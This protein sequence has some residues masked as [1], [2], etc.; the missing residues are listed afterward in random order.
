VLPVH[1]LLAAVMMLL[2]A[3]TKAVSQQHC[4]TAASSASRPL[5][6]RTRQPLVRSQTLVQPQPRPQ[7]RAGTLDW[8]S[9]LPLRL[10]FE[11]PRLHTHHQL[12]L[13]LLPL[14]CPPPRRPTQQLAASAAAARSL[15]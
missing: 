2:M 6:L 14:L 12:P 9:M 7:P 1:L 11:R 15:G 8:T 4:L 5:S 3:P 13:P 10:A